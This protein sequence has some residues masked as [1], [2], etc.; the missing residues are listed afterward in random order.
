MKKI[1]VNALGFSALFA[2]TWSSAGWAWG[3][4]GHQIVGETGAYLMAEKMPA[5]RA[6][7]FDIGYYANVPDIIWKRPATFQTEK[8]QHFLDLDRFKRAFAKRP[9][10]KNPFELSRKYFDAK[11]P[12]LKQSDGRSFWRIREL[13]DRFV[14]IAKRL[15]DKKD[16]SRK[17]RFEL[18]EKWLILAGLIGHYVGDLGMPLH[19][20]E[21]YDGAATGQKGIHSFFEDVCVDADYPDLQSAVNKSARKNWPK[22]HKANAKA[23]VLRMVENLAE[24]SLKAV[25]ELLKIDKKNSRTKIAATCPKFKS[26]FVRRMV[27]SSLVLGEIYDRA[28]NFEFDD[29]KFYAFTGEPD[30]IQPGEEVSNHQ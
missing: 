3:R 20:S 30:Y 6:H 11:F 17:E 8:T 29:K 24:D 26:L 28:S 16:I 22:F 25:P 5:F 21:N 23:S 13:N 15:H 27:A 9:E 10:I 12:E 7:S 18:Q 1:I 14:E 4:R 19:V 2:M